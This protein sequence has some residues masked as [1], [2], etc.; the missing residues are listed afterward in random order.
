MNI[1]CIN[2]E[3][4]LCGS[5]SI[6]CRVDLIAQAVADYGGAADDY[7]LREVDD[8]ALASLIAAANEARTTEG[9]LAAIREREILARLGEIDAAGA[10]ASRAVA[11]AFA[12]GDSPQAED[13]ARLEALEAE[14]MALRTEKAGLGG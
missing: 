9:Q 2:P 13:V 3:G 6:P 5:H 14:A 11:L 12:G 4:V 10:R 7:E 1:A 8:D